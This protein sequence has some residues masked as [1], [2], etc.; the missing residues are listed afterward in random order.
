MARRDGLACRKIEE[1]FN[2]KT[3]FSRFL[4]RYGSWTLAKVDSLENIPTPNL[5]DLDV[6][7]VDPACRY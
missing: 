2:M 1:T 4:N 3:V 7:Q 6:G 5:V